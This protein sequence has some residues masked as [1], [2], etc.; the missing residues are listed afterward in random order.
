MDSYACAGVQI[1]DHV[2]GSKKEGGDGS[3]TERRK[4]VL[5]RLEE[6]GLKV[7]LDQIIPI[8]ARDA[9]YR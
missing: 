5:K 4:I 3:I 1:D 2:E 7:Q 9:L 8:S 6:V